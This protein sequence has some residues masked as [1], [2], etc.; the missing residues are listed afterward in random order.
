V[1]KFLN[2]KR[3]CYLSQ[4]RR[5]LVTEKHLKELSALCC[6][7]DPLA[8]LASMRLHQAIQ[9]QTSLVK[10]IILTI[11]HESYEELDRISQLK[12]EI[13]LARNRDLSEELLLLDISSRMAEIYIFSLGEPILAA[14]EQQNQRAQPLNDLSLDDRDLIKRSRALKK[15]ETQKKEAAAKKQSEKRPLKRKEVKKVKIGQGIPPLIQPKGEEPCLPFSLA[16]TSRLNRRFRTNPLDFNGLSHCSEKEIFAF[17][18]SLHLYHFERAWEL[19]CLEREKGATAAFQTLSQIILY[20]LGLANEQ[21]L[22]P[23]YIAKCQGEVTH[24]I[25]YMSKELA[26]A[27]ELPLSPIVGINRASIAFRYPKSHYRQLKEQ[28]QQVPKG[29][30]FMQESLPLTNTPFL[31][32]MLEEL[33]K[34]GLNHFSECLRLFD[35]KKP[36][37]EKGTEGAGA[38]G[39]EESGRQP[40]F[41]EFALPSP[42]ALPLKEEGESLTCLQEELAK[43]EFPLEALFAKEGLEAKEYLQ[44]ALLHLKGLKALLSLIKAYPHQRFYSF[45]LQAITLRGQ[46]AVENLLSAI[47]ARQGLYF[48]S[49]AF[50]DYDALYG[51]RANLS[52]GAKKGWEYCDLKKSSDY[53]FWSLYN[54]RAKSS[55]FLQDLWVCY[56]L[57]HEAMTA[58]EGFLSKESSFQLLE[59]KRDL[60]EEVSWQVTSLLKEVCAQLF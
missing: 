36:R 40:L 12:Q 52:E 24:D 33:A 58:G 1:R 4:Q 13:S 44:S 57:S 15:K 35:P 56:A 2:N 48:R 34:E 25:A 39:P 10:Q 27:R 22:T 49:H 42:P 20:H 59:K 29:L 46:Y 17:D 26:F 8:L 19:F 14:H 6:N 55:S 7:E 18:S 50:S 41:T 16:V 51:V 28:R 45:Y 5:L 38:P 53:P 11:A 30:F 47:G 32:Q 37:F 23:L 31:F 54:K 21:L 9:G 60:L 43:L 3:C